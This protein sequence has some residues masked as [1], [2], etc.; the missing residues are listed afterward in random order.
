MAAVEK[1]SVSMPIEDIAWVRA[2]ALRSEMSVSAVLAEAV[3]RQRRAEA[4]AALLD[5]L[6][7]EDIS[8]QDLAAVRAEWRGER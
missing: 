5:D 3:R 7:V 2:K 4:L 8:E 1:L 6:G